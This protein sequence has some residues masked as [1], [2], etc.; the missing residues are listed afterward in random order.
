M[1]IPEVKETVKSIKEEWDGPI[2]FHAHDNKGQAL[3]N[4][5][6]A[7]DLGVKWIDGTVL[8][9]GRGAGNVCTEYLLVELNQ[10]GFE[11]YNSESIFTVV[12]EDFAALRQKYGWGY[13]LLYYLSASY[14][15]HP[16]YIQE[17]INS[18]HYD[19]YQ[20]FEGLKT[21]KLWD[22]NAYSHDRLKE[23]MLGNTKVTEGTW[24]ARN[25][26]KNK[27]VLVIGPGPSCK[28]H[29]GA[30]LE[31]IDRVKP[32]VISLNC[33]IEIPPEKIDTYA[34]CHYTRLLVELDRYKNFGK[35]ILMPFSVL[36]QT[37][38]EKTSSLSILDYGIQVKSNTFEMNENICT[39]PG[40]LVAPYVFFCGYC[41]WCS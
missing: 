40:F 31:Y 10:R 34:V 33:D 11:K 24:S 18:L 22:A 23:A 6:A 26:V 28:A 19:T 38:K 8:G 37:I 14:G 39:I 4:T 12:M 13:S 9:M 25:W 27:D 30:L 7:I 5:L 15:I 29:L 35:P 3:A 21:L 20:I 36:P 1:N 16:T 41:W 2:G 17:M 32:F